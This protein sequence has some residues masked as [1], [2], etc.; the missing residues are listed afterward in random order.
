MLTRIH[1]KCVGLTADHVSLCYSYIVI[2]IY[3]A[4]TVIVLYIRG[5]LVDL[6]RAVSMKSYNLNMQTQ[7][8][9]TVEVYQVL[10]DF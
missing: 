7:A 8:G 1:C 3:V 2:D 6:Y 5:S 4:V 9:H 10:T